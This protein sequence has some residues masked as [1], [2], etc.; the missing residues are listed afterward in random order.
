MDTFKRIRYL[1]FLAE[2]KR[3][4]RRDE[5]V[6]IVGHS[7]GGGVASIV[8]FLSHHPVVAFNS[9]GVYHS[10]AKHAQLHD[11]LQQTG[12]AP[13]ST[14]NKNTASEESPEEVS[15]GQSLHHDSLTIRAEGDF[16]STLFDDHMGPELKSQ[17]PSA[18]IMRF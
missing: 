5:Q 1:D 17:H 15:E 10:L 13:A 4:Y 7:M 2:F 16:I 9:P 8:G 3:A 6:V 12:A 11:D 18:I 14:H